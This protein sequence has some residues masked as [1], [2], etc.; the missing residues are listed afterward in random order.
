MR[1]R[2]EKDDIVL[3]VQTVR[4]PFKVP[5]RKGIVRFAYDQDQPA[6]DVEFFWDGRSL[7]T[8]HLTDDE[9]QSY[10]IGA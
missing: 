2:F 1:G 8:H 10:V 9:L 6:Y 3:L 5:S 7:G 4:M